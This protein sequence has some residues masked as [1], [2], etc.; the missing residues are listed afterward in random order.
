MSHAL[1]SLDIIQLSY[2]VFA[3]KSPDIVEKANMLKKTTLIL[4]AKLVLEFHA[5]S[6]AQ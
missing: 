2:T 3:S 6:P 1:F 4:L 5:S